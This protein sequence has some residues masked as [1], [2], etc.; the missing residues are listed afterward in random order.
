MIRVS[1]TMRNSVKPND[2]IPLKHPDRQ[3]NERMKDPISKDH[4]GY[5][6]E[7]NKYKCS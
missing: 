5:R 4:S 3:L 7:S 6:Q 2:P 1:S